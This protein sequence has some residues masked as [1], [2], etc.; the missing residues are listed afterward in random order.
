M[1]SKTLLAPAAFLLL[2]SLAIRLGAQGAPQQAPP[3][4]PPGA[5]GQGAVEDC[6]A[7]DAANGKPLWHSRIGDLSNAPQTYS[8]G[9]RQ[10]VLVAV[11]D[12]LY[13]F[14]MY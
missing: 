4:A 3:A 10:H 11:A 14:A 7:F 12:T 1:R 8:I 9:G 2:A 5:A 6:A 13:A